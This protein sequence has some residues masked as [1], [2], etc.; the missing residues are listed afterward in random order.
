[1]QE[2]NGVMT[3]GSWA[4]ANSNVRNC[5]FAYHLFFESYLSLSNKENTIRGP[6]VAQWV[7][8]LPLALVTM[9]GSW[10]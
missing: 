5:L 3:R 4:E 9:S 7:E 1:M 10:D 8:P 2:R 6:W